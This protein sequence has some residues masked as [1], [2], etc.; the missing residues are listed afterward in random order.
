MRAT[1]QPLAAGERPWALRV[2]V[3]AAVILPLINLVM[4]A[5][6]YHP[7][8]RRTA[9]AGS[10]VVYV[11]VMLACA[12]GM[13]Q[14]RYGAVLAFQVVLLITILASVLALIRASN[15]LGFAEALVVLSL[16]SLLFYKLIRVLSRIQLPRPGIGGR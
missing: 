15:L 4:L 16:A 6:G 14:K 10:D 3:A 1:L 5:A 12:I 7:L 2:A 9:S 11:V 13:W 8:G